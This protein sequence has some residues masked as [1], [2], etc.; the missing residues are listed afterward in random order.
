MGGGYLNKRINLSLRPCS[1]KETL[2]PGPRR[3][4]WKRFGCCQTQNRQQQQKERERRSWQKQ[5]RK[6]DGKTDKNVLEK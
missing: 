3:E 6:K 2:V 5:T 4:R 1:K